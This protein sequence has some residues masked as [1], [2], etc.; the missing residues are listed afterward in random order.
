MGWK[1]A[2]LVDSAIYSGV[3]VAGGYITQEAVAKAHQL[4]YHDL[5]DIMNAC[6]DFGGAV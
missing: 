3:N 2:S 1:Q 6:P 4:G 5:K